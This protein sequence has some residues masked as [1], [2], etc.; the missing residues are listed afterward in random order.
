VRASLLLLCFGGG[1]FWGVF[2]LVFLGLAVAEFE[3][4]LLWFSTLWRLPLLGRLCFG[5]LLCSHSAASP[6]RDDF[7][8]MCCGGFCTTDWDRG[9]GRVDAFNLTHKRA[10][11]ATLTG[12]VMQPCATRFSTRFRLN[13]L[14]C[15]DQP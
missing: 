4:S 3:A 11:D 7:S 2:D 6:L 13:A 15:F 5:G 8:G 9:A 12:S 10:L 14:L 1:R